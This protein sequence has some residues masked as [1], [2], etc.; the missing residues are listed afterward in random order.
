[1]TMPVW[2]VGTN[3][4]RTPRRRASRSSSSGDGLL[5]DRAV[6][7]DRVDDPRRHA[8]VL[9]R[10][11]AEV[12]RRA[13]QVA[14]LDPVPPRER[15]SARGRRRGTRAGRSRSTRPFEMHDRS[16]SRHAGREA[17]ALRGDA[18]ERGRRARSRA[19]RSPC[20]RPA[21]PSIV[22]PARVESRIGD[23]VLAPVAEDAARRL[24]VVRVAG[25]ALGEDRGSA[26]REPS[27]V[28]AAAPAAAPRPVRLAGARAGARPRPGARARL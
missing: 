4:E 23:D 15:R 25:E 22:S 17:P 5:A 19:R 2:P 8:Q 18:D 10:R 27:V 21:G 11:H 14:Q 9:A 20:R 1:M 13:A 16:S 12:V 7:P 24:A 3:C 26:A 6:G 28:A